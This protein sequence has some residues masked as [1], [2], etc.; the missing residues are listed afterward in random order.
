MWLYW[1]LHEWP[2]RKTLGPY[3]ECFVCICDYLWGTLK[4][5]KAG[6]CAYFLKT[7][8]I[9]I[10]YLRTFSLPQ[11]HSTML[12]PRNFSSQ[13][14]SGLYCYYSVFTTSTF[15]LLTSSPA[16]V[17]TPLLNSRFAWSWHLESRVKGKA[18]SFKDVHLI[19]RCSC[20]A[21]TYYIVWTYWKLLYFHLL[22]VD[23]FP[24]SLR[25]S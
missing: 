23:C 9:Q 18:A 10:L 24:I 22:C 17:Q 1:R 4:S 7:L 2:W 13:C 6:Q 19:D 21:C 8:Y 5:G 25:S 20:C 11:A 15:T 12:A 14:S 16:C 3:L